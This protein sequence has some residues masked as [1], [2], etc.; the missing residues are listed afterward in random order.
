MTDYLDPIKY[1]YRTASTQ[2]SD[3]NVPI[4]NY[5]ASLSERPDILHHVTIPNYY[6]VFD[7]NV[8][9]GTNQFRTDYKFGILTF[10]TSQEGV[11]I[12]SIT[13][14]A[15][16]N[17]KI[18][19]SQIYNPAKSSGDIIE[20]LQE[21]IDNGATALDSAAQVTK[22][23]DDGNAKITEMTTLE[24][25]VKTAENLRASNETARQQNEQNRVNAEVTREDDFNSAVGDLYD[26]NYR[27]SLFEPYNSL[28]QYYAL[29]K[30]TYNGNSYVCTAPCKG[31]APTNTSYWLLCAQKGDNGAVG[32]VN[33]GVYSSSNTYQIN[34]IVSYNG[35]TYLCKINNT[36][37]VVPTNTTYWQLLAQKGTDGTGTLTE[38]SSTNGNIKINGNEVTVYTLPTDANGKISSSLLPAIAITDT[39]P[40][41]SEAAM[42]AL[43]AQTGDICVRTDVTKSYILKGTD[44]TVL[45]NWQEL[46][47][48]TVNANTVDGWH[49]ND[50]A[51]AA[52]STTNNA[53]WTAYKTKSIIA[54][55]NVDKVDGWD[56]NDTKTGADATTNNALWTANK[57]K[58][59]IS[60]SNVDSVDNLHVN[61]AATGADTTTNNAIWSANKI[62]LQLD[63]KAN[64]TAVPTKTSQLTNDSN[65]KGIVELPV[66][67]DASSYPVGT[68]I[69][70]Y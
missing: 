11:I 43:T 18:P 5:R 21:I 57:V 62:K 2:I 46:L 29:N 31:I 32:I 26:T 19:A 12:P 55:S 48:T 45:A 25:N 7:Q 8:E 52:D 42:L 54:T 61:D 67:A 69:L 53:L 41:S 35:S 24:N 13:Y 36:Y 10:H 50:S 22:I 47:A 44:P 16:G 37:N 66:G 9:L 70:R 49:V 51:T 40:A 23:I 4:E 14:W 28:T 63:N 20:T 1:Q 6:E 30:V 17:A 59:V 39:F 34:D 38:A 68:I 3:L 64:S 15:K 33:K 65:F 27:F 56:V 60:T 58:T